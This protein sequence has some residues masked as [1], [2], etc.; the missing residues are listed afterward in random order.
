M[1]D[2]Y[3]ILKITPTASSQQIKEA[4]YRL[5]KIFHPDRN[6]GNRFL[7]E[8]KFKKITTAYSILSNEDQKKKYDQER[9]V[10]LK[11]K[12]HQKKSSPQTPYQTTPSPQTPY[13]TTPSPQTLDSHVNLQ[14][15]LED[16]HTGCI[17]NIHFKRKVNHVEKPIKLSIKIPQG[18]R[19]GQKLLLKGQSHQIKSQ[20][21]NLVIVI[22]VKKHP[23]FQRQK[24]NLHINLPL[25][26]TDAL[27]GKKMTIPSL[28]GQIY[29]SIKPHVYSGQ[30]LK[31][32]GQGFY[33][34]D[35]NTRGD[36][37]LEIK[38][39]IPKQ[40]TEED[41]KWF[42]DFKKRESPSTTV[43]EFNSE[44]QKLLL[45]RAS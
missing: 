9:L 21:G 32:K 37:I 26:I 16:S 35:G 42:K 31:L 23:L 19:D 11:F 7:S 5:A 41:K 20:K 10:H 6:K 29:I 43:I 40:I 12:S 4:Y 22:K 33:F 39:D 25:S 24:Q 28:T 14:I 45:Q 44:V 2:L 36:L 18:V 38:I 1:E 13:Q 3:Q 34:K 17:K 15:S 27:L 30:L 8:E